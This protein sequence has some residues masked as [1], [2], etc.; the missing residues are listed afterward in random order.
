MAQPSPTKGLGERLSQE[1]RLKSAAEGH[2][3]DH[4]EIAKAMK[5]TPGAVSRW[6]SGKSVPKDIM[7]AR[8][9]SYFGVT[10]SWLRYGQEPRIDS[11]AARRGP[12]RAATNYIPPKEGEA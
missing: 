2:D 7:I 4:R 11:G 1:R 5:V 10:A 9:A 6:E 8:L 12:R 3:I